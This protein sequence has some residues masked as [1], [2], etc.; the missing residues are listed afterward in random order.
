M[1]IPKAVKTRKRTKRRIHV[2]V[3]LDPDIYD[4]I[5]K[6]VENHEIENLPQL[7]RK[8][9]WIYYKEKKKEGAW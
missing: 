5:E 9:L 4:L 6:D 3:W 7:I 1:N 8:A 2:S